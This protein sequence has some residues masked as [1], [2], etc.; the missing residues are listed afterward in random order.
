[1]KKLSF[2]VMPYLHKHWLQPT[3]ELNIKHVLETRDISFY[4]FIHLNHIHLNSCSAASSILLWV[5]FLNF[6]AQDI[7]ERFSLFQELLE[8][9]K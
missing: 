5:L 8:Q 4:L 1:M 7:F 3:K 6:F 2:P 9:G